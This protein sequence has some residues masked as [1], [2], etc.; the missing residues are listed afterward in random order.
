MKVLRLARDVAV[1]AFL[2]LVWPR[3]APIGYY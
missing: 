1:L 3:D 2:C